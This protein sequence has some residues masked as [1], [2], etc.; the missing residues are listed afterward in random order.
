MLSSDHLWLQVRGDAFC[1]V[2][3][4]KHDSF[5]DLDFSGKGVVK[6]LKVPIATTHLPHIQSSPLIS[7]QHN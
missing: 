5:I 7:K 6:E 3:G 2:N 1:T 4:W